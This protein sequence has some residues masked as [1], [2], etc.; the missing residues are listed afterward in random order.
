MMLCYQNSPWS[1]SV[2]LLHFAEEETEAFVG[3]ACLLYHADGQDNQPITK[4]GG[5][6]SIRNTPQPPVNNP[7]SAL[8]ADTLVTFDPVT[9]LCRKCSESRYL[10]I[11]DS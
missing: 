11:S 1:K 8:K 3:A 4:T 7:G 10:F 2:Q 6:G 5:P 9:F